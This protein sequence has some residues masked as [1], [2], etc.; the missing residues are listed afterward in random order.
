MIHIK[1]GPFSIFFRVIDSALQSG[2]NETSLAEKLLLDHFVPT[3]WYSTGLKNANGILLS[4][5]GKALQI[6]NNGKH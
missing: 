2:W 5:G 4:L 3:S 6:T 1:W